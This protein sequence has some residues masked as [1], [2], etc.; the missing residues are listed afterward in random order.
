MFAFFSV[1]QNAD[2]APG[3]FFPQVV[4]QCF[5]VNPF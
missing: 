3:S 1:H 2:P 5:V 4:L